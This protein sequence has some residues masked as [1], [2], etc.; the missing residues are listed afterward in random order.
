MEA[1]KQSVQ[2]D[3]A[4]IFR[5]SVPLQMMLQETIRALGNFSGL[6]CVDI[7]ASNSML[8]LH[9]RQ[10]GGQ[11]E[12]VVFDADAEQAARQVLGTG[13]HVAQMGQLPFDRKTFD[14]VV[15]FDVLENIREDEKFIEEC[16]RILK[17]DGRLV[18]HVRRRKRLSLLVP[19]WKL[20]GLSPES[21]GLVRVGYTESQLFGILKH[22]FN[23]LNVHSYSRFFVQLVESCF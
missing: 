17:P 13:V 8:S 6:A 5:R 2:S 18:L 23:V 4:P 1:E 16:H 14:A 21:R 11:W 20:L 7:G 22:G 3:D 15:V 10:R 19:V 9:L 12:S